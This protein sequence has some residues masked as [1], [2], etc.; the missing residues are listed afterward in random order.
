MKRL[1]GSIVLAAVVCSGCVGFALVTSIMADQAAARRAAQQSQG[2]VAP[3][4]S[5][6]PYAADYF[7][8]TTRRGWGTAEL[9][10]RWQTSRPRHRV[11]GPRRARG[12]SRCR[13]AGSGSP[14]LTVNRETADVTHLGRRWTSW[15]RG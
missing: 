6:Q 10:G 7:D 2:P 12:L 14:P 5:D 13:S 4:I 9:G 1:L 8:R 3:G 11:R 15:P